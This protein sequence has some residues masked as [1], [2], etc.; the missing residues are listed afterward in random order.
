[1]LLFFGCCFSSE[2]F[3]LFQMGVW[4]TESVWFSALTFALVNDALSMGIFLFEK[5]EFNSSRI[6]SQ[7]Y[8]TLQSKESA[9]SARGALAETPMSPACSCLALSR[10]ITVLSWNVSLG[11]GSWA[12]N[13]CSVTLCLPVGS[14]ETDR[15]Q[16]SWASGTGLSPTSQCHQC[17]VPSWTIPLCWH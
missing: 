2:G 16:P 5:T 9:Q 8:S 4:R 14:S 13:G 7:D 12:H 3:D 10:G 11:R 1:M 6:P 17:P 15:P